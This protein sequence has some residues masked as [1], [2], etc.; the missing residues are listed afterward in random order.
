MILI[1]AEV[2]AI[3]AKINVEPAIAVIVGNRSVRECALWGFAKL[4]AS[5]LQLEFAVALIQEKQRA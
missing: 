4:K 2:V 5:R 3:Q 1:E